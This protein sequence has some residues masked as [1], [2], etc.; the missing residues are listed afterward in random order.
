[1]QMDRTK[2]TRG[3]NWPMKMSARMYASQKL[4]FLKVSIPDNT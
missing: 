1:M 4:G 2:I 3:A